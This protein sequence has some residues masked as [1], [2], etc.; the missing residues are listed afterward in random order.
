VLA[1]EH[2]GS[3]NLHACGTVASLAT[4]VT[5]RLMSRTSRRPDHAAARWALLAYRLP[6]EPS[7]PRIAVWRKLRRLGVLQLLDGLVALPLDRRNREHLE[8]VAQEVL[9]SGGEATLWIGWPALAADERALQGRMRKAVAREYRALAEAATAARTEQSGRR[10]SL[11][12]LRREFHRI[13]QRDYFPPPEREAAH[14]AVEDLA[15]GIE[16]EP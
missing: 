8:W 9:D 2:D 1:H 5:L 13:V 6:R 10:Q 4:T 3:F 16:V 7:T 15:S 14:R 11:A 12:R